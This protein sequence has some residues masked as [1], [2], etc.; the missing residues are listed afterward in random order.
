MINGMYLSTMG[1]MVQASRH[2]VV[3][4]NLA[5]ANTTGFKPDYTAH[6]ELPVESLIQLGRRAEINELLEDTGGGV[7]LDQTTTSY[8]AGPRTETGNP[9]HAAIREDNGF[10]RVRRDGQEF[11]TRD[12]GFTRNGLGQL[13]MADGQTLVLDVSGSPI[14]IAGSPLLRQDGS[15]VDT[16]T[17]EVVAQ[18]GLVRV[19]DLK[20]LRKIGNNLFAIG[21]EVPQ[22]G[23]VSIEGGAIEQSAVNPVREMVAMI[24]AA[25]AY[26]MNMKFVSIQDETLGRTVTQV[27]RIS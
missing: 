15:I 22:P 25:R 27:G 13:V 17:N 24:E 16:E 2:G 23:G 6:R 7:W 18:L 8:M 19:D 3:A 5:N 10:F 12:G 20:G 26:Q 1:A 11:L 14:E 21:E 4:N 9:L